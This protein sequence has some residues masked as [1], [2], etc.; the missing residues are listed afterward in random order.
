MIR[1]LEPNVL[2]FRMNYEHLVDGQWEKV[3]DFIVIR[4]M[5]ITD[6]IPENVRVRHVKVSEV[7]RSVH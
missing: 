4:D 2:G 5:L 6:L 3:N 7:R 1:Q